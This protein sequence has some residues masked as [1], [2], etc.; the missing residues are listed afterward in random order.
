MINSQTSSWT[1]IDAGVPQR[2]I[3][4]ALLFSAYIND[5]SDGLSSNVK[6]FAK[7]TPFMVATNNINV[8]A[9]DLE[10]K[11]IGPFLWMGFN[12]LKAT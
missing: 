7:G 10:K 6:L 12:C 9:S 1:Q 11:L 3:L 2:S 4:D 8:S 5:L